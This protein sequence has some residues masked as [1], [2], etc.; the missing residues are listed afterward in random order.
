[1][2]HTKNK[3]MVL[4]S[5]CKNYK[6]TVF[7]ILYNKTLSNEVL[8]ITDHLSKDAN[9]TERLYNIVNAVSTVKKCKCCDNNVR[10]FNFKKGYNTYCSGDCVRKDPETY[11]KASQTVFKNYGVDNPNKSKEIRERSKLTNLEKYGV[12]NPFQSEFFK[13]KTRQTNLIKYGCEY[14][15]AAPEVKRKIELTTIERF[16]VYPASQSKVSKDNAIKTCLAKYGVDS[17]NKTEAVQ[18]KKFKTLYKNGNGKCS[19]QQK[20]ICD[21]VKGELNYPVGACSLD[22]AFPEEWLYIEYDGSGHKLTAK[23]EG[24]SDVDF[25]KRDVRRKYL[26]NSKG[27]KEIRII[28]SKDYLPTE[29]NI[30]EILSVAKGY[31]KERSWITF[32]IDNKTLQTSKLLMPFDFGELK[33]LPRS[34]KG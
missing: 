1:M 18:F 15:S 4:H 11:I 3:I 7:T 24:I 21:V 26:L 2:E 23:Y 34:Y 12:E 27:W 32:N 19:R 17:H 10:F 33:K 9:F 25:N 28:S 8:K 22:V 20:Y 13:E 16:G 14:A 31:L 6:S 29:E 30:L 5:Q